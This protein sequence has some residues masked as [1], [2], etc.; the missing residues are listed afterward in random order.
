MKRTKKKFKK[1]DIINIIW[2][3]WQDQPEDHYTNMGM[4]IDFAWKSQANPGWLYCIEWKDLSKKQVKELGSQVS[5]DSG[6]E[7]GD[8][9][10]E[11]FVR[12]WFH[13]DFLRA[14]KNIVDLLK[15]GMITAREYT[16][17]KKNEIQNRGCGADYRR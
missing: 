4:I 9:E 5:M 15:A 6:G 16:K 1:G 8:E 2:K 17:L 12:I 7:Y 13:E 10:G 11:D 3:W 14:K